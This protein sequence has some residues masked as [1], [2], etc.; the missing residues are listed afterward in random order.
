MRSLGL[1]FVVLMATCVTG[2]SPAAE[3]RFVTDV[4][5]V[6][7]RGGCN[8]GTCHGNL[9][10]K[11]GFKLSLRGENPVADWLT[12][13]RDALGR[14]LDR[15]HP[16]QS[17]LLLKSTG[18][19]SHEGGRRFE[20]GSREHQILRSW[21]AN[22]A[23]G[24]VPEDIEPIA[25]TVAPAGPLFVPWR[26][27]VTLR[28][29]A[30]FSDRSRQ[31]VTSLTVFESLNEAVARVDGSG[32]VQASQPGETMVIARYLNQQATVRIAFI[33]DRPE[34]RWKS[35]PEVNFVDRHIDSKLRQ[36]RVNPSEVAD[37]AT[38]LRRA[39]LD[40][41]GILPDVGETRRF[42]DDQRRDKRSRL[43]EELV[44]RPEFADNWAL[45]WS[46]VFRN[47]E[48]QLDRKGVRVF[49]QWIRQAI[50]SGMPMNEFARQVIAGRGSSYSQPAANYYRALRDPLTRAEATAQVFLGVRLQCAKCHNHPFDRWKQDDYWSFAA[51]FAQVDYRILENNRRD[52]L[53]KHEF[54]GEQVVWINRAAELTHPRTGKR[55]DP[56]WLDATTS[57]NEGDRLMALADWVADPRNPFFA[58]MLVNRVWSHLMVQGLVEP[59]DDFRATNPP[60]HP[61]LIDELARDFA[62]HNF[63]LQHLVTTIMKS[64][65]YELSS[66]PNDDNA[67]DA[68]YSHANIRPLQ[69]EQLLDAMSQVLEVP[70]RFDDVPLGIRAGQLPG[71][72]QRG[73]GRAGPG[74]RFMKAFGKPERLLSCDCERSD[75]ATVMRAFQMVSGELL[76]GMLTRAGNRID[77]LI[78]SGRS[79][80]SIAQELYLA[81]IC[82]QPTV[83]ELTLIRTR[84]AAGN[85]RRRVLE[86]LAWALMNS[87]EFLLRR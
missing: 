86:D 68:N 57:L 9:N 35:P 4:M 83:D 63:S 46:D 11:G 80:D 67:T 31:D 25:V 84:L 48:K 52:R 10:G 37:D 26:D 3:P 74:E 34:F 51:L 65:T 29:S 23:T 60:T 19:V 7:S 64:R 6:F 13:T 55:V 5:A 16:D 17:L 71:T 20:T 50:S 33:A 70:V 45:K 12:I 53:D 77:R 59:N 27:E 14:R 47:E 79:N 18:A 36:L 39:F 72:Q 21:I 44:R 1:L 69:A 32:R 78:V 49:H 87:K 66:M 73:R 82:R 61:E 8:L 24:A 30:S 54:D 81:A 38:F 56:R 43:I 40:A 76:N 28:L 85:D 15:I 41:L 2:I 75:D 42:L 22:G 62:A 58:R